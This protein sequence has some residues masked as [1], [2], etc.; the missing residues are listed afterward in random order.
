MDILARFEK[1]VPMELERTLGQNN[2]FP[3]PVGKLA[4]VN[5]D[6]IPGAVNS[7]AQPGQVNI[8]SM[9]GLYIG[10]KGKKA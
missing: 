8:R 6:A 5:Q 4:R 3:E 10:L 9:I 2:S 1:A 7:W